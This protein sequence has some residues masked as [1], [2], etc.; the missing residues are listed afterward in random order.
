MVR[1]IETV[2]SISK[3]SVHVHWSDKHMLLFMTP[4]FILY[5]YFGLE[6]QT[7]NLRCIWLILDLELW[8]LKL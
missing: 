3:L 8:M 7:V 4:L 1:I 2:I 5:S 6:N